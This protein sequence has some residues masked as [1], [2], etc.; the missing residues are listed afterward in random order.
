M[1]REAL[2]EDTLFLACTRPAMWQGV[3]LEA[4]SINIMATTI[5]FIVMGNPLYMLI[6]VVI[7]YTLR[8]LV[9]YDYNMFKTLRLWIDTKGRARNSE[10]WGGSS[11]SPLPLGQARKT[12][13][14]RVHV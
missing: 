12:R 4:V 14:V 3:P 2:T 13:E 10:M 6:G 8:A 1:S 9:T 7:H 5:V 11:V